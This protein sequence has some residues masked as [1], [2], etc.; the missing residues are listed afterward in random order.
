MLYWPRIVL[1]VPIVIKCCS[2]IVFVFFCIY[3]FVLLCLWLCVFVV[4]RVDVCIFLCLCFFVRLCFRVC[5]FCVVVCL[6]VFFLFSVCVFCVF[7]FVFLRGCNL[8]GFIFIFFDFCL[9]IFVF[10]CLCVFVFLYLFLFFVCLCFWMIWSGI[11]SLTVDGYFIAVTWDWSCQPY[12][13]YSKNLVGG[14]LR[15]L[16][17]ANWVLPSLRSNRVDSMM[18]RGWWCCDAAVGWRW[19]RWCGGGWCWGYGWSM[20]RKPVMLRMWL[21]HEEEANKEE[22]CMLVLM[23]R[24]RMMLMTMTWRLMKTRNTNK[25][26]FW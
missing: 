20:K 2:C 24:R 10:L 19:G 9:C 7:A 8:Y 26:L 23:L 11:L 17:G 6:W 21:Q 13:I 14:Q 3:V 5:V 25:E 22:P 4:V 15:K 16:A 18:L 12:C 1:D